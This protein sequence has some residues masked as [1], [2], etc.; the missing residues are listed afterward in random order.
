MTSTGIPTSPKRI[1][2]AALLTLIGL[3][4]RRFREWI[5]AKRYQVPV[6]KSLTS[7]VARALRNDEFVVPEGVGKGL[8]IDVGGSAAAFVVGA[9]K[10]DLQKFME[11]NLK[12]GNAFYDVGANVGFFSL[13]A[14][15]LAGP[16]GSVISFEPIGEN[17][18]KLSENVRRNQFDNVRIIPNALG[19]ANGERTF[20][21]SESPTWGKL[22]GVA[23]EVPNKYTS[24][25]TVQVR[26][27]DD[28]VGG[29]NLPP[30]DFIKIDVEGA[31]LEVVEGARD[32]LL[33]YGPTLMIELH[34][35]N[36]ALVALLGKLGYGL[37]PLSST[38]PN[39][40]EAHWNAMTI[41]F[42]SARAG[43][44]VT[45]LREGFLA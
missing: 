29:E 5:L 37:L 16:E 43:K 26:R 7:L 28:L 3:M 36:E 20:Q 19:S 22:K 30:P 6:L 44:I 41:A 24:D 12:R 2:S 39:V 11:L 21:L 18:S 33:R 40:T 27:L 9:F 8:R 17:V 13:L 32:T 4:P 42:P 38:T 1:F 15:R 31:E 34:G 45:Q 10:P 14:A 23:Q 35:T 25:I